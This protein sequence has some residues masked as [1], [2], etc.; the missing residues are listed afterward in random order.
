VTGTSA[1]QPDP[2]LF[3]ALNILVVEDNPD[4]RESLRTLLEAWGHHV[5]VAADGLEG[6]RKAL[7][8][9]PEIALVDIGL[10]LLDGYQV[11]EQVR[12]VLGHRVFLVAYTAYGRWEDRQRSFR[13]GFNVHLTKPVDLDALAYWL[14]VVA[15][16]AAET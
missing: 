2:G 6:V 11:A 15:R 7:A 1:A 5:E 4:G 16:R 9:V 8:F 3:R 14:A 12:A 13:A 10:P